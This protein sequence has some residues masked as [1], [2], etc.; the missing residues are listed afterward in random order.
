MLPS[1]VGKHD[2]PQTPND[3]SKDGA[4][5][6]PNPTIGESTGA[7]QARTE[8]TTTRTGSRWTEAMNAMPRDRFVPSVIY[9]LQRGRTPG[10]LVP[11][12]RSQEPQQWARLVGEDDAVI[13]Q[14]DDGHPLPD[15][16]GQ[17]V[18]SSASQPSVVLG[19]LDALDA[20][21]GNTVLEISTGTGWNAALLASVIGAENVVTVEIDEQLAERARTALASAG[22]GAVQVLAADAARTLPDG[23]FDRII[24]T[25]GVSSVPFGWITALDENG[26]LVVPLNNPY[27]P[28]GVAVLTRHND[29][30]TGSL[31]GPAQFMALRSE[32]VPRRSVT[33]FTPVG[34]HT[35]R[36]TD[37]HPYV[38]A[39]NR[40]TAVAIGQRVS[41]VHRIWR[42]AG[43][44]TGCLWLYAPTEQS[45]ATLD[46]LHNGRLEVEQT[47]DRQLFN[48]VEAAHH[49]WLAQGKPTTQDWTITI[50]RDEQHLELRKQTTTPAQPL[51]AAKPG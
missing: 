13:I 21:P 26:R 24:A 51:P 9:D 17:E 27:Q 1:P 43:E 15:G 49:W 46:M 19:M 25:V 47:G 4:S 36:M 50:H 8:V 38:L 37:L 30:A 22:Y 32:R 23:R 35:V 16:S 41:G 45:I 28:P 3:P 40:D 48:E 39:G 42:P 33:G 7:R 5:P 14:V 34:T 12:E 20:H 6:N 31:A 2:E 29:A 44:D 11:I 18:T 10:D